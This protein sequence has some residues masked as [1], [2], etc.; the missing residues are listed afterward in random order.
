[1]SDSTVT[2][3]QPA[4]QIRHLAKSFGAQ[5]A[6]RDVDLTVERG[7]IHALLGENGAGK[8]TLIKI[9]AGVYTRD[10]GDIIINGEPAPQTYATSRAAGAG[11]AF[12]HQ[13]LGLSTPSR[14]PT[15]L[16]WRPDTSDGVG[17]FPSPAPKQRSRICSLALA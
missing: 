13:D 1:M 3:Q 6:L 8:S 4:L 17:S 14:S 12:V 11:L 10:A 16:L 5:L 7:E 2:A 15:T 9:L